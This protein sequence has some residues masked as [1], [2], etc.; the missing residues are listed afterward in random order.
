MD[1]LKETSIPNN[2]DLLHTLNFPQDIKKLDVNQMNTLA[3]QLVKEMVDLAKIRSMHVSSNLGVIHLTIALLYCFDPKDDQIVFDIGHQAYIYKMLTGRLNRMNT[4][5]LYGGINGFQTPVESVYDKW[6]AGHSGTS[7]SAATGKYLGVDPSHRNDHA[8]VDIIGDAS[9][10]N[11]MSL[12]A[13]ECNVALHAPM[14]IIINDNNMSIAPNFGGLHNALV[15]LEKGTNQKDNIFTDLGYEYIGVVDGH[16]MKA[17]IDA[18]NSAKYI[19]QTKNK[20]VIVHV[21][22]IK[23]WGY[24][25]DTDGSYHYC[26]LGISHQPNPSATGSYIANSLLERSKT[27]QDFMIVSPSITDALGLRKLQKEDSDYFIDLGMQEENAMTIAAGIA[28]MHN[29]RPILAT[30]STF[31]LRTYDQIWH[32]IARQDLGVTLMLDGADSNTSSGTSH[33]G[34]FDLAMLKSIPNCIVTSGMTN[35]QNSALINLSLDVNPDQVF[36][37]RYAGVQ[38]NASVSCINDV[39]VLPIEFKQWQ[40]LK[41]QDDNKLCFISYGPTYLSIYDALKDYQNVSFI[42][43]MF[44]TQYDQK[45]LRWLTSQQFKTIV[46]YE[47]VNNADPLAKDLEQYFFENNINIKIVKMNFSGFLF[48]APESL[49]DKMMHMDLDSIKQ[50]LNAN[51]DIL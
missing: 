2:V 34:L 19:K 5:K 12:E 28:S 35:H 11:G 16:N 42:N 10:A 48:Q 4:I 7:L 26:Q 36:A 27:N 29:Y 20:S 33:S 37:V 31:V 18:F 15:A 40:I 43:A 30:T 22:T 32:D 46:V 3:K 13:L 44:I 39:D 25:Q 23:G 21:K 49:S 50:T 24:V 9:L 41:H 14:I 47:R 1:E 38:Y 17:L 8:V 51:L 6:A 45:W